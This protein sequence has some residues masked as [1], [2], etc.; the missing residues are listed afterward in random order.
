MTNITENNNKSL[1]DSVPPE[2]EQNVKYPGDILKAAR[3]ARG[4]TTKE[5][6][7]KLC[8]RQQQVEEIEEN[9]FDPTVAHT[10]IR[11]YLRAYAKL[12][13]LDE[14]EVLAAYEALELDQPLLGPMQSFSRKNSIEKQDNRLMLLT[15]IVVAVLVASFVLFFI[16]KPSSDSTSE[17]QAPQTESV[18]PESLSALKPDVETAN[19]ETQRAQNLEQGLEPVAQTAETERLSGGDEAG[20]SPP[21]LEREAREQVLSPTRSEAMP[22]QEKQIEKMEVETEEETGA[23]TKKDSEDD[24]RTVE[25]VVQSVNRTGTYLEQA[26]PDAGDLVLYFKAP[27]WVEVSHADDPEQIFAVGTK[28]QGYNMPLNGAASYRVVLGAMEVVEIYYQGERV[29]LSDLPKNRV[30]PFYVPRMVV[31]ED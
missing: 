4:L 29:D 25:Q 28:Q 18:Q 9:R 12:I 26:D 8:L 21:V 23:D 14:K 24:D 7:D 30:V 10:F 16:Q 17:Q 3:E 6:A 22:V 2:L 13:G 1:A 31:A 11:G 19:T 27:S 15:Y 20:M 5:V